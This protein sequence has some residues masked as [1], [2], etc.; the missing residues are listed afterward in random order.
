MNGIDLALAVFIGLT[1]VRGLSR[2]FFRE[3]FAVLA[4]G[5]AITAAFRFNDVG[6]EYLERFVA[7]NA[8]QSVQGGAAFVTIFF[9][10][11]TVVSSIGF[12]FERYVSSPL[13]RTLSAVGGGVLGTAKGAVVA[14]FLALFVYLFVPSW[15]ARLMRSQVADALVHLAGN[16]LRSVDPSVAPAASFEI[17]Q[18]IK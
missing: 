6:I 16:A 17:I 5:I 14:G 7:L 9:S 15:G 11:Y 13:A 10:A 18:P 1:G 8:P 2:G 4:L 12:L 3:V